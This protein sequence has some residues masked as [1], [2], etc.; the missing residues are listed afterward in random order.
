MIQRYRLHEAP[1]ALERMPA[2]SRDA[3]TDVTDRCGIDELTPPPCIRRGEPPGVG[4]CYPPLTSRF[5]F[6]AL[7]LIPTVPNLPAADSW[8]APE[9]TSAEAIKAR[10]PIT[11]PDGPTIRPAI[12]LSTPD[13]QPMSTTA[14]PAR[15]SHALKGLPVPAIDS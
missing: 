5:G 14:S 6:V 1:L 3:S 9:N 13:P 2:R 11:L 10:L 4:N 12:K 8:G 7:K 15:S